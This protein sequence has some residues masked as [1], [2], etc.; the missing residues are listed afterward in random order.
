MS[1]FLTL[2][3]LTLVAFGFGAVVGEA[4]APLSGGTVQSLSRRLN[5]AE[6]EI[7]RLSSKYERLN[8]RTCKMNVDGDESQ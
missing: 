1:N 8:A 6:T 4:F 3:L 2:V 5:S 7:D